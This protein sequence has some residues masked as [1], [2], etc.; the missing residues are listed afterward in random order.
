MG[1]FHC[2]L[3]LSALASAL[4]TLFAAGGIQIIYWVM[5]R[6]YLWLWVQLKSSCPKRKMKG[7]NR[8]LI[9][10][11]PE[12]SLTILDLLP[13]FSGPNSALFCHL[14]W[15]IWHF[16]ITCSLN[17]VRALFLNYLDS[18][19]A[20][21]SACLLKFSSIWNSYFPY[22]LSQILFLYQ[23]K[24]LVLLVAAYSVLWVLFW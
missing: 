3:S 19:I 7:T 10:G 9:D 24:I 12:S 6:A 20:V 13:V 21:V 18:I 16:I 22:S 14:Y 2:L 1:A 8:K 23:K 17:Q 4:E 11:S 5:V 15:H